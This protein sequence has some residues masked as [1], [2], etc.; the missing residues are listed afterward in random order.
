M[1]MTSGSPPH[2]HSG[3]SDHTNAVNI[4]RR[5]LSH[6]NTKS[7]SPQCYDVDTLRSLFISVQTSGHLKKLDNGHLSSLISLF[8][9]LSILPARTHVYTNSLASH[10]RISSHHTYWSFIAQLAMQQEN[11]DRGLSSS[12][13]YW[14][15][16]SDLAIVNSPGPG[17]PSHSKKI[18]CSY[19][20]SH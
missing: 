19:S 5:F 9:T 1:H 14:I 15:M 2:D 18:P 17:A 6:G 3:C 20:M 10:I 7:H 4:L 13:H 11:F 16:R 8:G 12:D